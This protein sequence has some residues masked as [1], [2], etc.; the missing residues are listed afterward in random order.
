MNLKQRFAILFTSFVAVILMISCASIYLLYGTYRQEDYYNRVTVE[1]NDVYRLFIEMKTA[2]KDKLTESLLR[3]HNKPLV[4]EKFYILDSLGRL[5][6]T[7]SDHPKID[8]PL[9][10]LNKIKK[11][12]TYRYAGENEH[13]HIVQYKT[14]TKLYV[15][16]SGLDKVGFLKLKT[17]RL[18]LSGVFIGALFL[19]AIMSFLFVNEAI[20]PIVRLSNQMK[21]TNELN[22]SE[23]IEVRPARDEINAIAKNFNAMLERL[24]LAF[25]FQ[26]SFVHH[27][28]HELRTPLAIMLSQT[29]SAL[30]TTYDINGYKAVLASLKEDQL[31]LIALTNSLLL[32]SQYERAAYFPEWPYLRIDELL[33][34][35]IT[36]AQKSFPNIKVTINF[37][38]IPNDDTALLVKGNDSLLRSAFLNLIKNGYNYSMDQSVHISVIPQQNTVKIQMDNKGKQLDAAEIDKIMIPFFRGENSYQKKGYGLGLSIINRIVTIHKGNVGYLAVNTDLNRFVVELPVKGSMV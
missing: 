18:I 24:K 29:E 8:F 3:M 16:I 14:E 21:R 4:N 12:G 38:T 26:K 28:S 23:R 5:I 2:G 35:T 27:A 1:G 20:K 19:T 37:D 11:L 30:N 13:Q 17:L 7:F 34:E 32:L 15:L 25:E 31:Q 6:F 36:V 10:N 22:L 33:Y 9:L